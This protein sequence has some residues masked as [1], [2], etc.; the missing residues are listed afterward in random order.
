M[1]PP[2]RTRRDVT[3]SRGG[4]VRTEIGPI[5]GSALRLPIVAEEDDAAAGGGGS[6]RGDGDGGGSGIGGG[7]S[8]AAK[9]GCGGVGGGSG[10][11][12]GS[13]GEGSLITKR[14]LFGNMD[15]RADLREREVTAGE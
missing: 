8:G 12:A 15:S 4:G 6:V 9:S 5:G 11:F 14:G 1:P 13:G 2:V 10:A 3:F 7:G